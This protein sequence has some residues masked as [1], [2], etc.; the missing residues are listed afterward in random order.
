MRKEKG[1]RQRLRF[2]SRPVRCG[3]SCASE[4]DFDALKD[5]CKDFLGLFTAFVG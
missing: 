2:S 1:E 5:F 3:D 4:R